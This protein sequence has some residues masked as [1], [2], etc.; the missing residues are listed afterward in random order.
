[1]HD[2][3]K[4]RRLRGSCDVCRKRKIR[5]DSAEKP[6]EPCSHCVAFKTECT[7][8]AQ[9]SSGNFS[10]P[11]WKSAQS[12]VAKILSTSVP[13]IR[14]ND[15]DMVHEI[16]VEVAQYARALEDAVG[17]LR[18]QLRAVVKASSDTPPA[19]DGS[20]PSSDEDLADLQV[21]SQAVPPIARGSFPLCLSD[22]FLQAA[23]EHLHG[24][25]NTLP[26]PSGRRA[27]FWTPQPWSRLLVA[28][29]PKQTFPETDLLDSLV[30]IYFEE[31]NSI[32]GI[33][34]SRSFRESVL[35]GLHLRNPHFG[36][37][38]LAVCS[39]ASRQS[40]DPR[41]LPEGFTSEHSRGLKFFRQAQK[42]L[43]PSFSRQHS[44][45]QLQLICLSIKFLA[46]SGL[47]PDFWI[48]ANIG[49]R[50]AQAAGVHRRDG[51]IGMDPAT[52]EQY[53]RAFW[54]LIASDTLMT[55]FRGVSSTI[56]PAD[57]DLELPLAFDK[58]TSDEV[59]PEEAFMTAYIQLLTIFRRV[60]DIV[61]G[62]DR[63]PCSQ[64]VVVELDS[65]L[66]SWIDGLPVQLRWD[67]SEQNRIALNQSAALH[68]LYYQTQ[69]LLHRHF[70]PSIGKQTMSNTN[71]PS[72]AICAT[73][74]RSCVHLLDV[75]AR[76]GRPL[77]N[78]HVVIVLFDCAVV[79][80]VN[81][82]LTGTPSSADRTIADVRNCARVLRLYEQRWRLA[83]RKYDIIT[84]MLNLGNSNTNTNASDAV[85][86][87]KAVR[88]IAP[89]QSVAS[90][91]ASSEL[92]SAA[93]RLYWPAVQSFD[94]PF[95]PSLRH[96]GNWLLELDSSGLSSQS[97]SDAFQADGYNANLDNGTSGI[98]HFGQ[99][100]SV[101]DHDWQGWNQYL[102]ELDNGFGGFQ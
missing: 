66:N 23:F 16:L 65:A 57:F 98:G 89:K 27:E 10:T 87:A 64:D 99:G 26:S 54:F 101:T 28:D 59:H 95:S 86:S 43:S 3:A 60:Q 15:P 25:G 46:G 49:I 91:P 17:T 6:G 9:K 52:A 24:H 67:P 22:Q 36:A 44:L 77:H 51:Y 58:A 81:A 68:C 93:P 47:S 92:S 11:N 30:D 7:H 55:T 70:I 31:I 8:S 78:A 76:Q 61:N 21:G 33:L 88:S 14:P 102:E 20:E 32:T 75:Q 37:V 97:Q 96:P 82:R 53:K 90:V 41:V 12:H 62:P 73:A 79:L 100:H 13:Y 69:I 48:W 80:M 56:Q 94:H 42:F 74:A 4:R 2:S 38:V 18:R 34:H 71:S 35:D 84:T 63:R 19:E 72:L 40:Q 1:M 85:P 29:K 5:C 39:I 45:Y 83:G 50:F